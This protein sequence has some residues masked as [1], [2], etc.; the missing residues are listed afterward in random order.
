M[1]IYSNDVN[2]FLIQKSD[3]YF[4]ATSIN[5]ELNQFILTKTYLCVSV[6]IIEFFPK[7]VSR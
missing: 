4:L 3:Y 2:D 7:I 5:T 1:K 6:Y